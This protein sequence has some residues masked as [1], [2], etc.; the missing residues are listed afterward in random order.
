MS[1]DEESFRGR[2]CLLV[3]C[4]ACDSFYPTPPHLYD[5]KRTSR[6]PLCFLYGNGR[7]QLPR[8]T[9]SISVG[10]SNTNT[11]CGRRYLTL[12]RKRLLFVNIGLQFS[13]FMSAWSTMPRTK[14]YAYKVQR[15]FT[16]MS[17]ELKGRDY[18]ERLRYLNLWTLEQGKNKQYLVE[19][20][21]M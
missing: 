8:R 21:K 15:R 3:C 20:Y 18:H 6:T 14:N 1:F 7:V 10:N 19:I 9:I 17:K 11:F 16:R 2:K 5:P 12:L 4:P 13:N